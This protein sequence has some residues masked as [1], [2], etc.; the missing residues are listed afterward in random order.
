MNNPSHEYRFA[1]I[2]SVAETIMAFAHSRPAARLHQQEFKRVHPNY[3][4]AIVPTRR[5][6]GVYVVTTR[7]R[8]R[9]F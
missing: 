2:C 5:I 1:V 9:A 8:Q 4:F 6:N 7:D 3:S